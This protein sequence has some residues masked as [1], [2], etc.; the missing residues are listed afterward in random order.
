[1][2]P[3]VQPKACATERP[4]PSRPSIDL[5]EDSALTVE[6]SHE[7]LNAA[8]GGTVT[9]LPAAAHDPTTALRVGLPVDGKVPLP[10]GH[11]GIKPA[12]GRR[13]RRSRRRTAGAPA[14]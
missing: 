3:N 14:D 2:S 8:G 11:D 7:E 6:S 9:F 4:P 5:W 10:S 13:W 1:M 12:G